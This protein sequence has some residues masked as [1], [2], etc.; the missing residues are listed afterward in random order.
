MVSYI[1]Y[2]LCPTPRREMRW[3]CLY[4]TVIQPLRS[5]Q[6]EYRPQRQIALT[7]RF[8]LER[9]CTQNIRDCHKFANCFSWLIQNKENANKILWYFKFSQNKDPKENTTPLTGHRPVEEAS[10]R[11]HAL[12]NN[13]CVQWMT[14]PCFLAFVAQ[15]HQPSSSPTPA[16]VC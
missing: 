9:T 15:S 13:F 2:T 3:E 8:Q 1:R 6:I 10:R 16:Q 7:P 12:S 5:R 4:K 11:D 14:T